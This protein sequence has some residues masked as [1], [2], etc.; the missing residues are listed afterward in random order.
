MTK[1]KRKLPH[2]P[3]RNNKTKKQKLLKTMI[4]SPSINKTS[5]SKHSCFSPDVLLYLKQIY[6]NHNPDNIITSQRPS[7]IWN[8]F[9][10]RLNN[11]L[12]E[13][14]WLNQIND[15]EI[16]N[17][18]KSFIF[19]PTHPSSWNANPRQWLSNVDIANVLQQYEIKF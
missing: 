17:K 2:V 8:A 5:M 10:K 16:K 18:L 6:N 7:A 14:C 13:E 12:N 4:C 11:C 15:I 3:V 1:T 9:R 19:A